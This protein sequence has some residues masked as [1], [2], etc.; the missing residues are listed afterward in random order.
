MPVR[1]FFLSPVNFFRI[2][3]FSGCEII[4]VV[5][6]DTITLSVPGRRVYLYNNYGGNCMDIC[7][8][9]LKFDPDASENIKLLIQGNRD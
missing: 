2:L 8:E 4:F 7:C 6:W 1:F 9:P 3:F 5:K